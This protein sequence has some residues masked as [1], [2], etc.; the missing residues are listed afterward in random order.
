MKALL[1]ARTLRNTLIS[2]AAASAMT[3]P[4]LSSAAIVHNSNSDVRVAYDRT[5]LVSTRGLGNLYARLKDASRKVCGSSNI[6]IAGSVHHS[7]AKSQCYDETLT[8]AV[9][10]LANDE[11][12][13][14][15]NN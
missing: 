9:A 7:A 4:L 5:T 8:A 10:R 14:L 1:K 13:T 11:I 15:H 6:R 12:T 3:L 2:A